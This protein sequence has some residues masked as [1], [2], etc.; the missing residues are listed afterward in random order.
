MKSA[1]VTART[2]TLATSFQRT[3][4]SPWS[5]KEFEPTRWTQPTPKP[6]GRRVKKWLESLFRRYGRKL[7]DV[8]LSRT[9]SSDGCR[10]FGKHWLTTV[11]GRGGLIEPTTHAQYE[12]TVYKTVVTIDLYLI[13]VAQRRFFKPPPWPLGAELSPKNPRHALK[14]PDVPKRE[15]V[16]RDK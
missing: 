10:V 5:A 14:R 8:A 2:A 7:D 9:V 11:F 4:L 15:N 13:K 1:L 6:F 3:P 16:H 12:A